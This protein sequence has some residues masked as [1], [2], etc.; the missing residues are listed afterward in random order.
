MRNALVK[1]P[2]SLFAFFSENPYGLSATEVVFTFLVSNF[3]LVF[4]V[5]AKL[6]DTEGS[7]LSATFSYN[8][9]SAA[10]EPSE[11]LVYLLAL[12]APSLW[13]MAHNW[14]ARKHVTFYWVLLILQGG[15]VVGSAYIYGR[16]KSGGVGNPNF[17][18]T[19]ATFCFCVGLLVWYITLAYKRAY[20]DHMYRQRPDSG[21]SI[22]AELGETP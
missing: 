21:S 10:V 22:L 11:V 1:V 7:H 2:K 3:A 16:A 19:W 13:I 8:V 15:I 6:V 14:R 9:I 12:I 5:F 20:I 4:L 17:V 18:H